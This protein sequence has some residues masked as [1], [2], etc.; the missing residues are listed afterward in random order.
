VINGDGCDPEILEEA[1]VKHA[2]VI[3]AVT[4]DDIDNIIICNWQKSFLTPSV[5]CPG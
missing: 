4:G 5:P 2:D 3:A 1:G